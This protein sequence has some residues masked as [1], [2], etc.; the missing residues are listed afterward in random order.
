[1]FEVSIGEIAPVRRC[2]RRLDEHVRGDRLRE[3]VARTFSRI[4]ATPC[5]FQS[6]LPARPDLHRSHLLRLERDGK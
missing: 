6:A 2:L 1:M 4:R 5:R 3:A